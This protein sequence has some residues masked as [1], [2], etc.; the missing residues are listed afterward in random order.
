MIYLPA[1]APE[2]QYEELVGHDTIVP[3]DMS[4]ALN[5]ASLSA[6]ECNSGFAMVVCVPVRIA[7]YKYCPVMHSGLPSV[8]Q[9]YL[10]DE[11]V[12]V[13]P[14]PIALGCCSTLVYARQCS[15]SCVRE[16][17]LVCVCLCIICMCVC[18]CVLYALALA[19]MYRS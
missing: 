5:S 19:C 3:C 15:F 2:G 12:V 16:S 7:N 6:V 10:A 8:R 4:S 14:V 17:E 18:V 11:A 9:A 13:I 1:A